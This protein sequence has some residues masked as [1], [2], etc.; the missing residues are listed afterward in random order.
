[1]FNPVMIFKLVHLLT[2]HLHCPATNKVDGN[3]FSSEDDANNLVQ[4]NMFQNI[5][6]HSAKLSKSRIAVIIEQSLKSHIKPF[7]QP[8]VPSE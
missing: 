3:P 7:C 8:D 5:S 4:C 1:M 6:A 2:V